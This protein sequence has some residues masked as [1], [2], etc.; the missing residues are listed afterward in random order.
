MALVYRRCA[1]PDIHRDTVVAC[2]RIRVSSGK[3]EEKK[4]TFRT[5]TA[6]LKRLA[7]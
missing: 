1:G 4:E 5:F 2:I 6:D 3:H 7:E